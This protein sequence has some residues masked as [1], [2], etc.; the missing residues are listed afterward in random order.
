M[1]LFDDRVNR[2]RIEAGFVLADAGMLHRLHADEL[3]SAEH[4]LRGAAKCLREAADKLD[5]ICDRQ[6]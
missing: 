6:E 1:A 2:I 5:A 3:I 4:D